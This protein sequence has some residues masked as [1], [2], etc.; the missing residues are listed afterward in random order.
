MG[1]AY[2]PPGFLDDL[3]DRGREAWDSWMTKTFN[4]AVAGDPSRND[5]V[6]CQLF[7]AATPPPGAELATAVV[8]WSAFPN[9]IKD[10]LGEP[11][12]W[13]EA[14]SSRDKQDEYCEWS[15]RRE[16]DKIVE[17]M[18]TC[19]GPEYWDTLAANQPDT[20]LALYRKYLER[21]DIQL[22]DLFTEQDGVRKYDGRNRFNNSTDNGAMHL[23][24]AAN[25]LSAEIYLAGGGSMVRVKNG[26][27]VTDQQELIECG[28]YGVASRNSD[29][30]I[31]AAVNELARQGC[32]ISLQNPVGLY[33]DE[34]TVTDESWVTPDGASAEEIKNEFWTYQRGTENHWV[35]ASFK[36]PAGRGYT[37]SDIVIDDN[38]IQWGAQITDKIRIK[39]T[40]LA[41]P[42]NPAA[43]HH[44][45]GCVSRES[46]ESLSSG[47]PR[48][49]TR[50]G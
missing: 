12:R 32:R 10:Q 35:R 5:G 40:G 4:E 33:F 45:D 22:D 3:D 50:L 13:A 31:G 29:P 15:V 1:Y 47:G 37:V 23:I 43:V 48:L 38:P 9:Q 7:P 8:S 24:M 17:V 27:P 18:F 28:Q 42:A 21:D 25:T 16:G 6:R 46:L 11:D 2:D 34:L 26:Q 30:S 36:V 14:D 49:P 20:V 19:E 44:V 39:L 41:T